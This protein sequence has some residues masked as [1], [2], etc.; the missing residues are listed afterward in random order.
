MLLVVTLVA[1]SSTVTEV[2]KLIEI[3]EVMVLLLIW[4]V[5]YLTANDEQVKCEPS[6]KFKNKE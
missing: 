3:D 5:A 6:N 1:H 2:L 4:K